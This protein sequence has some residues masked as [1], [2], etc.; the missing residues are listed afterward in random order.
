MPCVSSLGLTACCGTGIP[1]PCHKLPYFW[2]IFTQTQTLGMEMSPVARGRGWQQVQVGLH[3]PCVSLP[4]QDM[5]WLYGL[6]HCLLGLQDEH[7]VAWW[8]E[9]S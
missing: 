9:G 2:S 8:A 4:T 6:Q 7:G 1:K 5:L 3:E